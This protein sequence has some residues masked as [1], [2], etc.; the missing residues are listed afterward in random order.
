MIIG[1][2]VDLV[3]VESFASQLDSPGTVYAHA[4]TGQEQRTA[5]NRAAVSGSAGAHLAARWA[6]KEAF[7]KAWSAALIAAPPPV[8]QEDLVWSQIEVVPDRW[9]R[10]S[11]T[12]HEPLASMVTASLEERYGPG[13]TAWHVSLSHDGG[14]AM[15]TVLGERRTS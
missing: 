7:I 14:M 15:A 3:E 11:L 9:G 8:S 1:V 4:F 6:A 12:I 10:P 2:G 13:S 5:K